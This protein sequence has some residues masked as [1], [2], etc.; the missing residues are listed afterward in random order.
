M[1][2][3]LTEEASLLVFQSLLCFPLR[4]MTGSDEGEEKSQNRAG[5]LLDTGGCIYF[6]RASDMWMWSDRTPWGHII[7]R[8][9]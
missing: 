1:P 7:W 6:D 2:L 5:E 4:I 9:S 8:A 3:L